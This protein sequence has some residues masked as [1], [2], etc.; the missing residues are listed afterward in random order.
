MT[1]SIPSKVSYLQAAK[2]KHGEEERFSIES[3]R[4]QFSSRHRRVESGPLSDSTK[5][6]PTEEAR[7]FAHPCHF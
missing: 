6:D 7:L 4:S 3:S 5:D 1:F 2:E